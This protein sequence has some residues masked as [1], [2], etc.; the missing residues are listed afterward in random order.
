M[1][2]AFQPKTTCDDIHGSQDPDVV[3]E[4]KVLRMLRDMDGNHKHLVELHA[5]YTQEGRLHLVTLPVCDT[6]P[7]HY[8]TKVSRASVEDPDDFSFRLFGWMNCLASATKHLH[9]QDF[10][11]CDLK[12]QNVLVRGKMVFLSDFGCAFKKATG[13]VLPGLRASR[14]PGNTEYS[15]PEQRLTVGESYAGTKAGVFALVCIFADL[16]VAALGINVSVF[17][18]T[19]GKRNEGYSFPQGRDYSLGNITTAENFIE[20]LARNSAGQRGLVPLFFIFYFLFFKN[21]LRTCGPVRL[22]VRRLQ[23]GSGFKG[24]PS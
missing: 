3:P 7:S 19:R 2:K 8:L 16:L 10:L 23:S 21:S 5:T 13:N 22:M 4:G 24:R 1:W 14:H 6:N 15:A 11:H 17:R 20:A 12:P 9:N 18:K